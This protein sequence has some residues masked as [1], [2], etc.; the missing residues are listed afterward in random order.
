VEI[1]PMTGEEIEQLLKNAYAPPPPV[2][3]AG[4]KL[5]Q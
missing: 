2:V 1:D 4:A 3:E 5:V